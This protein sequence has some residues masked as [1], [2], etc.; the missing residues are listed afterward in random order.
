VESMTAEAEYMVA[1]LEEIARQCAYCYASARRAGL[2]IPA[3]GQTARAAV[4][5]GAPLSELQAQVP[6][7][8]ADVEYLDEI[9]LIRAELRGKMTD[10]R[11][12]I[13]RARAVKHE[14]AKG[15]RRAIRER[16]YPKYLK[17]LAMWLD[18][19]G[20]INV[21]SDGVRLAGQADRCLAW[22]RIRFA[23]AYEGA[24]SDVARGARLP[25]EGRWITGEKT[26][27]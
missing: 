6:A 19:V 23:E 14:A 2:H 5:L 27:A 13:F 15:M 9:E 21:A 18:A 16:N 10:F 26:P 20:A 8:D 11:R 25:Y 1:Q 12:F 7:Y 3:I 4:I 24:E 17:Y 22:A